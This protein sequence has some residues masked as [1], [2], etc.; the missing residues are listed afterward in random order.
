MNKAILES[1]QLKALDGHYELI[2]SLSTF[3]IPA[4]LQDSLMARLDRLMTAKVIAHLGATIG[5]QFSYT[6][7]QA[8]AQ[9]NER[10][11]QEELHRLVEAELLYQ[12][13]LPP[14]AYHQ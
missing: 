14:E 8:V 2:G 1:G 5:R 3:A 9:L 4:T 6:L 7:L 13:G 11:L 10:T 12:R